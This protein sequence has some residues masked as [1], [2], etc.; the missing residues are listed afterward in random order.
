MEDA[1]SDNDGLPDAWESPNGLNP[2]SAGDALLDKDGDGWSNRDEW[3]AGT[4]PSLTGSHFVATVSTAGISF[5]QVTGRVYRVETTTTLANDWV[6]FAT[7]GPASGPV[8]VPHPLN[9]GARRFY[10]VAI[11]LE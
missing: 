9:P 2:Y 7:V 6:S 10:R 1:D 5:D 8:T 3:I 4:D 11:I